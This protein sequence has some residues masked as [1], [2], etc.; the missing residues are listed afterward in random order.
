MGFF[1]Y[2]ETL[3]GLLRIYDAAR[4]S[5]LMHALFHCP[6]AVLPDFMPKFRKGIP[7]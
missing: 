3:N 7:D 2:I 6:I 5:N 1:D 4:L